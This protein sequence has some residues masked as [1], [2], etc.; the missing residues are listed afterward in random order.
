M[1]RKKIFFKKS[2]RLITAYVIY[3]GTMFHEIEKA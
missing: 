1:D 3:Y 2:I